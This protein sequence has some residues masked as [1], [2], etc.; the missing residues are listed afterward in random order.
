MRQG[1]FIK[2]L[3]T[4]IFLFTSLITSATNYYWV[5]NSGNWNDP[6]HWSLT[7]GGQGGAGIPGENDDAIFNKQSFTENN[8]IVSINGY[9]KL[10]ALKISSTVYYFTLNGN[11]S[12][13]LE[14]NGDIDVNGY[15]KNEFAGSIKISGSKNSIHQLNFGYGLWKANIHLESKGIYNFTGPIVANNNDI[16]FISGQMNLNQND[17]ICNQFISSGNQSRKINAN[18]STFT[19]F[20]SWDLNPS[21]LT[22]NFSNTKIYLHNPD[23]NALKKYNESYNLLQASNQNNKTILNVTVNNDTVSC[24]NSCDGTL[25]ATVT[26]D[27]SCGGVY[28]IDWTPGAPNGD[29]TDTIT[30]LCPGTYTANVIDCNTI[31]TVSVSGDVFGHAQIQLGGQLITQPS[32]KDSCDGSL[33]IQANGAS[34]SNFTFIWSTGDTTTGSGSPV[35]SSVSNLC[36]GPV[37]VQISDGF[38]CDTTFNF[39]IPEPDYVKPNVVANDV[40]C[41]GECTGTANSNPSGGNGVY[42]YNWT[43]TGDTTQNISNLCPGNYMLTV[44]DGNGCTGDTTITINEPPILSY[45]TTH[46]NVSCGGACDGAVGVITIAGGIGPYTH[47]WTTGATTS[48]ISNLCPGVYSDT[49]RDQNGCDTIITF[50]VTEPNPLTLT[51]DSSNVRCFNA[52]DGIAIAIAGGGTPPYSYSWSPVAGNNDSLMNLCPGNYVVTITDANNCTITDSINITQPLPLN[53]NGTGIDP[54]CPTF[55]DGSASAVPI[56]GTTPYSY[57]WNPGGQTSSSINSLCAGTYTVTVT[58]SNNCVDVDTIILMDPPPII[59]T[60]DSVN[61]SCFGVCDGQATVQIAGGISPYNVV[62]APG[63]QTTTTITGLCAGTYT[64][65]VT[66]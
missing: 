56:G 11:S 51:M 66:D 12:S 60:M 6:N 55:C 13:T 9:Y 52:C 44:T 36:T 25:I 48:S 33:I 22:Y 28:T 23:K 14:I 54:T 29:G 59:L 49:L 57:S 39:F 37:S 20:N 27:A 40:L 1:N 8:P 21:H 38:G 46:Q 62:W 19:V 43:P 64:V 15:F 47:S 31:F 53:A 5:G 17:I 7:S 42:S 2:H 18:G 34:Y 65:T 61:M 58:D 16:Y 45:D 32:C 50:N 10:H 24:G 26:T 41:F 3:T 4:Y 63:G 30:N 35:L